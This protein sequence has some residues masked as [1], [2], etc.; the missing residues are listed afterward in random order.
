MGAEINSL[1]VPPKELFPCFQIVHADDDPVATR[2]G[3][4]LNGDGI[5]LS[6]EV[7]GTPTVG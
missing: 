7:S 5:A 3:V 2:R 4:K 1:A 6:D